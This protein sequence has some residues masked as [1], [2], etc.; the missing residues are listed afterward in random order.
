[1]KSKKVPRLLQS[2]LWS[3]NLDAM[4]L[5]NKS[6]RLLIIEQVF[7]YGTMEQV[8]WVLKN[9]SENEFK[10]VLK[11]PSRGIWYPES[12][13]YWT[14]VYGVKLDRSIYDR[15]IKNIYPQPSV[16]GNP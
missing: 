7:N 8:K 5:D 13:T 4:S 12:L 10:E 15:A 3:Y 14:T 2:A 11:H 1:M 16:F 6:D 9:L